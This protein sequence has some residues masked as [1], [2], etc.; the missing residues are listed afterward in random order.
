MASESSLESGLVLEGQFENHSC[1]LFVVP[2]DLLLFGSEQ[3][4][5]ERDIV[6]PDSFVICKGTYVKLASG[7]PEWIVKFLS[8]SWSDRITWKNSDCIKERE[9]GNTG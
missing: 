9:W 8:P 3:D 2:M 4:L 5:D 7:V 6:Q 1:R